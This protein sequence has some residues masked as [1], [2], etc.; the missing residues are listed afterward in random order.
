MWTNTEQEK[1]DETEG[2][3]GGNSEGIKHL[4]TSSG[5]ASSIHNNK[6]QAHT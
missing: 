4:S 5:K 3:R 2:G 6:S 1:E